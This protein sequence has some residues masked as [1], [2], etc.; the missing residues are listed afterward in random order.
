MNY[1]R[2]LRVKAIARRVAILMCIS[3]ALGFSIGLL[4]G[5]ILTI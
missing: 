4:L 1:S 3:A 5:H 2:N